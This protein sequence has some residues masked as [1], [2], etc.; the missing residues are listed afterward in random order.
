MRTVVVSGAG[1]GIGR[2]IAQRFALGGDM[3]HILG[4]RA[5][6]LAQTVK[7]INDELGG[8]LVHAHRTDVSDLAQVQALVEVLPTPV[9][10]IVNNAGGA[11]GREDDSLPELVAQAHR[12]FANN[13][14]SALMVTQ[15]LADRLPR[16]GGRVINI[17]SIAGLRGGGLAYAPAKAAV[18]GLTYSLAAE[19]GPDGIT[20]NAVAPGYVSGTEFFG[21]DMTPE[22]HLNL[23]GQTVTGRE[24]IPEDVAGAVLYLASPDAG[25]VTGQVL[26]VNGGALF[27]RG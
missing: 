15:V 14:L 21:G 23:V 27:G 17:S 24:G 20:V 13:C 22:R 6:V 18:I 9:D 2:A 16:P 10:V 12:D 25:Q 26:Q 3:V 4:R 11:S 8:D 1:T 5:G 19:L 7:R